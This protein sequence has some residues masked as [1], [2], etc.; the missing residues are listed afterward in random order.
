MQSK[1]KLTFKRI[2]KAL[3][4]AGALS[5]FVCLLVAAVND[6]NQSK[7]K[8]IVVKMSGDDT[9]FFISE[10]DI[11]ALIATGPQK[12]PVGQP[13]SDIN[14]AALEKLVTRDPWVKSADIFIDNDN[15]LTVDVRQRD[16]LARVFTF[17]GN[18]FYLDDEGGRIPV[19]DRHSA[20][21][22]VFTGFPSDGA[23]LTKS[24]SLLSAQISDLAGYIM[25]D[26]FWL[27]QVEQ[28]VI[29]EDK[30]FEIIPKLGDHVIEFGQGTDVAKKFDKLLIFYREG[31]SKVGWNT[32]TRINIAYEDQVVGTRRDGKA[33]PPPPPPVDSTVNIDVH[34]AST[35]PTQVQ[36]PKPERQPDRP[37]A[38]TADRPRPATAGASGQQQPRAIYRPNNNNRN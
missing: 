33:A 2:G 30:K 7:V 34:L 9:N 3:L 16:P 26:T 14:I 23:T 21:V 19:S 37:P 18:S 29:T 1:T 12:N 11:K 13:I 38:R 35:T 28:V 22:P 17:T 6:K 8:G 5:G 32:Y 4:W 20:R 24:D 25:K 31:L 15:R 36:P 27:A 10:K